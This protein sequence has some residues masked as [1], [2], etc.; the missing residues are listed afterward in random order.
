MKQRGRKSIN[1]LVALPVDGT[2]PRLAAPKGLTKVERTAF[3]A[4]V[5][6][7]DPRHFVEADLPLLVSFVQATL[8]ARML[9]KDASKISQWDKVVRAQMALARS[10]RL[11]PQSRTDPK[12]LARAYDNFD[13]NATPPWEGGNAA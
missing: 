3:T 10:L 2:P 8:L 5:N 13:P 9:A 1:N 6:A 12:T 7:C 11:T 4:L